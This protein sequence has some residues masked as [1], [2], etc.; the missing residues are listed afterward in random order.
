MN[1]Y[2]IAIF[3]LALLAIATGSV[4]YLVDTSARANVNVPTTATTTDVLV[5]GDAIYT[6]GPYGFVIRYPEAAVVENSFASGYHLTPTWRAS[7]IST[8]TGTP[9]VSFV[10]YSTRSENSY[11]RYYD[12]LIRIGVSTDPR[13]LAQCLKPTTSQGETV[14]PDETFGGGTWKVFAFE[15]AGMQQYV[16]GVS[17][18]IV[19]EGRCIALEKMAVGSSYRDAASP[20]DIADTELQARYDALNAVIKTFVLVRP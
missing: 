1:R 5:E 6:N 10:L 14:L 11:P 20:N 2:V 15:N 13:E 4:W 8:A 19:H 3:I 16:K 17:Y 18:R 9:I 12:A 7:A